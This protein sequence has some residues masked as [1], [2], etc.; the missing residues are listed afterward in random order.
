MLKIWG[1]LNIQRHIHRNSNN[2]ILF[3]PA[4]EKYFRKVLTN[5]RDLLHVHACD[6]VP[7]TN[8]HA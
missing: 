2:D 8:M 5:F 6:C 4:T 3:I 7:C 1:L